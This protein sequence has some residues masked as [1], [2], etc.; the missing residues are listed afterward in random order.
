MALT[1]VVSLLGMGL[2]IAEVAN[3]GGRH[4][5]DVPAE[6]AEKALMLN[7]LSQLVYLWGIC[8]AK[9]SIG[10]SLLRIA[11]TKFWKHLI[12][13]FS[14]YSTRSPAFLFCSLSHFRGV[15]RANI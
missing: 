7:F 12:L 2:V 11:S 4:M 10:T 8:F 3:R 1:T 14:K 9:I 6:Q 13:V 15:G 5:G